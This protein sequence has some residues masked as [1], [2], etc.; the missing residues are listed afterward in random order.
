MN[1]N[2]NIEVLYTKMCEVKNWA[3]W[4]EE[5]KKK[6]QTKPELPKGENKTKQ[7]QTKKQNYQKQKTNKKN[8]QPLNYLP[9]QFNVSLK[10]HAS[11]IVAEVG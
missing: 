11:Y 3:R 2:F 1:L 4:G 5:R 8:P 7:K 9:L 6:N 10:L